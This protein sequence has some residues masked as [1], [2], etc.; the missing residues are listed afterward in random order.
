MTVWDRAQ[1]ELVTHGS[2][3]RRESVV[4]N[5]TDCAFLCDMMM[6]NWIL[7]QVLYFNYSGIKLGGD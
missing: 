7:I 5:V 3:V 2:A 6:E 4:R 1:I